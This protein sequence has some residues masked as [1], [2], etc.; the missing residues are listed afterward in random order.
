MARSRPR[1]GRY[2][3]TLFLILSFQA[4]GQTL[5]IKPGTYTVPHFVGSPLLRNVKI[6]FDSAFWLSNH[7]TAAADSVKDY[8]TAAPMGITGIYPHL[9][10]DTTG[11]K[12]VLGNSGTAL[13]SIPIVHIPSSSSYG[14]WSVNVNIQWSAIGYFSG[15]FTL[16]G[17][18]GGGHVVAG[19]I[20][21]LRFFP[22]TGT[23]TDKLLKLYRLHGDQTP[24]YV[25]ATKFY[26]EEIGEVSIPA[27]QFP[28]AGI[29]VYITAT[30]SY[31][32]KHL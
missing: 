31:F 14:G 6:D 20:L 15:T 27:A 28:G 18:P 11:N 4:I 19:D 12:H 30:L 32:R 7:P 25:D 26:G 10:N 17:Y 3:I 9:V 21:F 8:V 22:Q 29:S 1:R 5:T 2:Y 13:R 24:S 16:A 23:G